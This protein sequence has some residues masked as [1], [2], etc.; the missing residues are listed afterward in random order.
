MDRGIA[1]PLVLVVS[2][3]LLALTPLSGMARVERPTR[4]VIGPTPRGLPDTGA[5]TC[6][7]CHAEIALEWRGSLHAHAWQDEVFQAAYRVEPMAFCRDCHA[8]LN[9]G[10]EPTG[11]AAAE[12]VSCAVCHVSGGK[13]LGPGTGA[14]RQAPHPVME[15]RALSESR[16]CK[17]CHQFNFPA[18]P[19]PG[20]EVFATDE[21]MQDTFEEWASSSAAA[22]GAQCQDCHMP[23]RS[24]PADPRGRHRSHAFPG[25]NDL[26]LLRAAVH[27]EVGAA[28]DGDDVVVT[29]RVAPAAIGHSFPTGDLFR[30]AELR[31]WMDGDEAQGVSTAF[32]REFE[33]VLERS[34]AG[35]LVFVKRE[36]ADTRVP[37]PGNGAPAPRVLRLRSAR[38]GL[39][40]WALDHLLMPTPLA[41]SQGIGQPPLNQRRVHSGTVEVSPA[42]ALPGGPL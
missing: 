14:S 17:G 26:E 30:R 27:V 31:V 9:Q 25:G 1:E 4:R 28:R 33:S 5:E 35:D 18:D 29:V 38:G 3:A 19:G 23:W 2:G 7:L 6:A 16:T 40:R 20:R 42:P 36:A 32:A 11:A 21:P 22:G 34:P 24:S 8:P 13:L 39:V 15:V 41:A 12:G 10:A 37:P